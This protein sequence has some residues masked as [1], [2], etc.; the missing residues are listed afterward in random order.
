M[1][2]CVYF[3]VSSRQ[4]HI[5]CVIS[6]GAG[7]LELKMHSCIKQILYASCNIAE[8]MFS[9]FGFWF[10]SPVVIA[11]HSTH[12]L[13]S[14]PVTSINFPSALHKEL[15]YQA[16]SESRQSHQSP[17]P[18]SGVHHFSLRL[19]HLNSLHALSHQP[20][21]TLLPKFQIS[22]PFLPPS[23]PSWFPFT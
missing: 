10:G 14:V 13:L 12:P 18:S 22:L 17:L 21:S 7:N 16:L 6:A 1:I 3:W 8:L 11:L 20:S 4:Q 19:M 5:Y 15:V 2:T 23:S 9:A